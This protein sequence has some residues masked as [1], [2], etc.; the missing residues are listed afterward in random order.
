MFAL[1][2]LLA[3]VAADPLA[4]PDT[5]APFPLDQPLE[6]F[7]PAKPRDE[8]QRARVASAA[9]V[10]ESRLLARRRDYPAALRRLQRAWRYHP[11]AVGL[12][13]EIV[14]MANDLQRTDESVRYILIAGDRTT[15]D[16]MV[17]RRLALRLSSQQRWHQALRLYEL[18]LQQTPV[19]AETEAMEL[20]DALLWFD[21]G[22]ISF[23]LQ[24][25]QRAAQV[26]SK[27]Q[28]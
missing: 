28:P 12:L 7:V 17:L 27:I 24:D 21:L 8:F 2:L 25:Y 5:S 11:Q 16:P 14:L 22:R 9:M 26:F 6:P 19:A 3:A 13:R 10:A 15:V 1:L 18:L 4:V 20:G 23:L